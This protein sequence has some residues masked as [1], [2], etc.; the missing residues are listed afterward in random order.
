LKYYTGYRID[1]IKWNKEDQEV[2]KNNVNEDGFTSSKINQK[3]SSLKTEAAKI[4]N[5]YEVLKKN[6]TKEIFRSELKAKDEKKP[7]KNDEQSLKYCFEVYKSLISVS[8]GMFKHIKVT[9][10]HFNDFLKADRNISEITH[11]TL[12]LFE[13][14]LRDCEDKGNNTIVSNMKRLRTFF[15]FAE[16]KDWIKTDPFKKYKIESERYGRPIALTKNELEL[17]YTKD[18]SD[19]AKLEKVKDIF[20]FQCCIGCR[21]SDL[22]RLT[23]A[24]IINGFIQYIPTK[25]KVESPSPVRIPINDKARQILKKYDDTDAILP[26]ISD[27][28]YNLYL[29]ELF[30]HCK[31]ERQVIR[32][33]PLTGKEENVSLAD[34]VSSHLARRTFISILHKKAKDSVIASM[35]GHSK[36]SKAFSRYYDVDDEQKVEV[37]NLI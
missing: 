21:V 31:L 22:M 8:P 19:N 23:K 16:M 30:E 10:K 27:V 32:L 29:K 37:I 25:T 28:K 34:I 4:Y 33:N 5:E 3:L 7:K 14:Y 2:K 11:E 17:L 24:N 26:F 12:N 18:L 1:F 20:I 15:K 6:L 36:T 35:T 9:F 13:N